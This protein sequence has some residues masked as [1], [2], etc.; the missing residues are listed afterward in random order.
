MA[1]FPFAVWP[2]KKSIDDEN[3]A[4]ENRVEHIKEEV[5]DDAVK[6]LRRRAP[7]IYRELLRDRPNKPPL[8]KD[9]LRHSAD[10]ARLASKLAE[11][12]KL[13]KDQ[14][15]RAGAIHDVMRPSPLDDVGTTETRELLPKW[16][17]AT[18]PNQ[19]AELGAEVA[20][21]FDLPMEWVNAVRY[22]SCG[23]R[24]MSQ[25]EKIL[26]IADNA[27]IDR[28]DNDEIAAIRKIMEQSLDATVRMIYQDMVHMLVLGEDPGKT[29]GFY[30]WLHEAFVWCRPD[31]TTMEVNDQPVHPT[32]IMDHL[33]M[34]DSPTRKMFR[35]M[36][37]VNDPEAAGYRLELNPNYPAV[38]QT[39][40]RAFGEIDQADGKN[41]KADI[42][43]R[44]LRD[45]GPD[46]QRFRAFLPSIYPMIWKKYR[47]IFRRSARDK[48]AKT[49]W[50]RVADMASLLDAGG[51]QTLSYWSHYLCP[52]WI[53]DDCDCMWTKDKFNEEYRRFRR[54][55]TPEL[56]YMAL[57]KSIPL[58]K[59]KGKDKKKKSRLGGDLFERFLRRRDWK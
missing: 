13:D 7:D 44:W 36:F 30:P 21:R 6:E 57:R 50:G 3:K 42:L 24:N 26:L 58:L 8:D 48:Q 38:H 35:R 11:D 2:L 20:K 53:K 47:K 32:S 56:D 4:I 23:R 18:D 54:A 27:A 37:G 14:A 46:G 1:I 9:R 39:L 29:A 34:P 28:D 5:E 22:H 12:Y 40:S 16:L 17:L 52:T 31:G 45:S 55:F 19:H 59:S 49:H 25:E 51:D 15:Y 43:A 10:V 33:G 41:A